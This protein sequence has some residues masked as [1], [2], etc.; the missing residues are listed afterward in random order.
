MSSLETRDTSVQILDLYLDELEIISTIDI[1]NTG[2]VT[3]AATVS[4]IIAS[5][6]HDTSNLLTI[7]SI[8]YY[9][10][11]DYVFILFI[12]PGMTRRVFPTSKSMILFRSKVIC[13]LP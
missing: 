8:N 4:M 2:H 6:L 13:S 10:V 1:E 11:N 7:V 5:K 12:S 3:I 9:S